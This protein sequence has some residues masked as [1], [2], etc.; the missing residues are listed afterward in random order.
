MAFVVLLMTGLSLSNRQ[1]H[2]VDEGSV[3][4]LAQITCSVLYWDLFFYCSTSMIL[5]NARPNQNV[6]LFAGDTKFFH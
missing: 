6:K 4:S 5:H 2:T 1:P 3:S